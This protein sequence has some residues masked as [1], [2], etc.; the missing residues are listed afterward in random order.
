MPDPIQ[1]IVDKIIPVNPAIP[2]NG[3]PTPPAPASVSPTPT[4]APT[5][6]GKS[7][8]PYVVIGL[9]TIGILVVLLREK[10]EV[11]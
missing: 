10:P 1:A 2:S 6:K 4:G 11:K 3:A 7:I 9:L 5:S 8:L